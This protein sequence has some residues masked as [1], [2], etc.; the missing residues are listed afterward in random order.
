MARIWTGILDLMLLILYEFSEGRHREGS[1]FVWT[2]YYV[3]SMCRITYDISRVN[4]A[5]VNSLRL[6]MEYSFEILLDMK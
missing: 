1:L 6:V 3:P 4:N 2:S 5:F